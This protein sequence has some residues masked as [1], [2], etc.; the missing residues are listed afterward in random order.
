MVA[1]PSTEYTLDSQYTVV[2]DANGEGW[3]DTVGPAQYGEEWEI[4]ATQCLVTGSSSESRLQV[5]RN[6]RHQIVE[7][8]YS[9]N[10][11][12]SDTRFKLRSG[13]RLAYHFTGATAGA[14]ATITVSGS[15]TVAG[16]RGY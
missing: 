16:R 5:Y 14:I 7:G 4:T 8:T 3:I 13:E 10:Q 1:G 2:I 11:D 12:N 15:R 9:G 6:G